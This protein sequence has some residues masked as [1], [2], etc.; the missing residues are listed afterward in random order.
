M[1]E[2]GVW[3]RLDDPAAARVLADA[4]TRQFF[5]PFIWRERLVSDVA[6]ELGVSKAAVLYRV[7]Q[8]LRL[9]LLTV[10]R[11]EARAGRAL[12]YYRASSRGYFVPFAA[13]HADTVQALYEA[14]LDHPRRSVLASLA[15]VWSGLA[16]DARDYGLYTFGDE[17]GLMSHAL[18]PYRPAACW[19]R[20]WRTRRRPSGTTRPRSACPLGMPRRC[21]VTCMPCTAGTR[22]AVI[23]RVSRILCGSP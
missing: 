20:F 13:T 14:S 15:Q 5:Q 18:L 3:Q 11:T 21:S 2:E 8:F 10:T 23:L 17:R 7:R 12:K 4:Y 19:G 1:G 6:R 9:G 22:S 16:D